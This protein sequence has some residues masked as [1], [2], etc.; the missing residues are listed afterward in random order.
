LET[1]GANVFVGDPEDGSV[2]SEALQGTDTVIYC[3]GTASALNREQYF[4]VNVGLTQRI[5]EL[6]QA[7]QTL[8]FV[9]S[10]AAADPSCSDLLLDE[11]AS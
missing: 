1:A 3:A 9:S 6:L 10:Q 11:D 4:E 5:L 8:V 2:M 7:P